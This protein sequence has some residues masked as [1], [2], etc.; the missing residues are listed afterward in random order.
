MLL[1]SSPIT[2]WILHSAFLSL[3]LILNSMTLIACDHPLQDEETENVGWR[4][5]SGSNEYTQKSWN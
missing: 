5:Y 4:L 2:A 3:L 1:L